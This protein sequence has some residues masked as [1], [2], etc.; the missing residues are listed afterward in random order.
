VR[1]A[2]TACIIA[3][4]LAYIAA[5]TAS[6]P[7]SAL[8]RPLPSPSIFDNDT[9]IDV[10]LIDM[11]ITNHGSFA[12]DL[13]T[14]DPGLEY[15]IGTDMHAV[16]ASGL[17][18][19]ALIDGEV[20]V[21]VA[22][23]S[24]EYSPGF[25]VSGGPHPNYNDPH[26]RVYKI[27]ANSGPGD[28]DWDE[29]P[30]EEGAPVDEYGDPLLMGDQTLW[31]VYNDADP[32]RHSNSAGQTSPLGLEIQLTVFAYD[33]AEVLENVVF[34]K[35]LI[36]NNGS[37]FLEETY[38]SLW[39][40]PDLGGPSDDLV[41]CDTTRWVGFCYN[42][43]NDD[44]VYG[45]TPPCVAYDFLQ[46]PIVPSPGDTAIV[47]G[48]PYPDFRN[49]PMTSFN[50]YIN[51]T[52]P[53]SAQESYWYML[54]LNAVEPP[55]PPQP[56]ID[57]TTGDT[58]TYVCSGDPVAGTGWLDGNPADRRFMM[59]SGPFDLDPISEYNDSIIIG[60]TAQEVWT[61]IVMG[62]GTD[63]LNSITVMREN[64]DIAQALFQANFLPVE[65][66]P[67]PVVP[68]KYALYQNFP[69]PFNSTTMI[70]FDIMVPGKVTLKVFNVLGQEVA[71]LVDGPYSAGSH[72]ISWNAEPFPSGIY[73]C[74]METESFVEVKKL[75]LLK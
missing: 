48:E 71:T 32:L 58:T 53:H 25:M 44:P 50:K 22:E 17:W 65:P 10:N 57:P 14:L 29:W 16:F 68:T 11:F 59:S 3:A 55:N 7:E 30:W 70:R 34:M 56:Y 46:G 26:F 13:T 18:V 21:T 64:D 37:N 19:G 63:R 20:H 31:C 73:F 12:W 23:Y 49:L 54:G 36:I 60:V 15:P 62:Q 5:L 35:F 61:A 40:D 66:T 28:P 39:S 2:K 43:D 45:T 42:A 52:D 67:Y 38:L 72:L 51:G 6:P 47:S 8:N 4:L 74:R 69:N 41:G 24:T 75:L 27:D 33:S 9:H 1:T